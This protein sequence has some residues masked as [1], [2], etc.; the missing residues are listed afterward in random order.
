MHE[1]SDLY[2]FA[3]KI[4]QNRELY[5]LHVIESNLKYY[6]HTYYV[7]NTLE[8]QQSARQSV[9]P[10]G[11]YKQ[12]KG[13][14]QDVRHSMTGRGH[15]EVCNPDWIWGKRNK[16]KERKQKNFLEKKNLH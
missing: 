3:H 4:H 10:C 16:K 14:Y 2:R 11:E 15:G 13:S 8:K 5:K 6:L 9:C 7:P 12:V 1:G